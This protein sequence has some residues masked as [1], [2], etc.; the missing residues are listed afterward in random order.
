MDMPVTDAGALL[1]RLLAIAD[2]AVIVVDDDLQVIVFNQGAERV[3]G[4]SAADAIG[5]PL[6]R[7]IPAPQRARHD[8]LVRGFARSPRAAQR[9]GERSHVQG[10]RADGSLFDAEA[11]I[12]HVEIDGR[13]FFTAILR[14]VT[15]SRAAA[16]ALADSEAR[17]RGLASAAPVG[18][19]LT[20]AEGGCSYVNE[21]WCEISG[22]SAAEAVGQG[23]AASLHPADRAPV[24][25]AWRAAV[26]AGL[27]FHL[28]YRFVRADGRETWVVG[29][30][31]AQRTSQGG[32]SGWIGT[33][34]D[35][36]DS[37][38]QAAELERAKSEAEAATRAKSLFLANMSH[39]IRTPLNA[40]IGMTTL[41]Q[42]TPMSED[43][44]D[45]AQTIQSSSE[46][47]LEIINDILDYSKADVGKL[48]LERR[49]FDLRH[50][51]EESLDLVAP[52]ALEKGINL[53]YQIADG[54]PEA[55]V[56]D[57]I[58]LRQILTNLLSNAVKF[59]HQGEVLA[60]VESEAAADGSVALHIAVED[61]GI[62]IAAEHLPR[63]FQRFT[64]VDPSTTRKY[65]GTGLGL[66]IT[67]RLAELMG[68]RVQAESTPGRGS[69][70]HAWVQLERTA[71][72]TDA[73]YLQRNAPALAGKRILI[74]DDNQTNRRI[75]TRFALRWGMQPSTLPSALEALDRVRHGDAFDIALL[76][77]SMPDC[78]GLELARELHAHAARPMP[79]VLLTSLGQRPAGA[80]EVPLAACLA[81]PIKAAQLFD[82]LVAVVSGQVRAPSPSPGRTPAAPKQALRVLIAEDHPINQ[83]V[84]TRLLQHLG[85]HAD[86]ADN[87]AVAIERASR[88]EYDVVLM[89][90]QMPEIDGLEAARAI[91]RRRGPQGLPRIIAMTASAMPGD[92]EA[93]LAAGMD[94]YLAKPI[95]LRD[96]ADAL[97]RVGEA[98]QRPEAASQGMTID[99]SRLEHLRSM[100]DAS[101]P[102]LVRELIDMF[103]GDSAVHVQRIADALAR[104]DAAA[105]RMLA[106]R[107]LS[108]TQN[109]GALRLSAL[110]SAAEALARQGR[111]EEAATPIA[112]LPVERERALAELKALRLRY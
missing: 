97:G 81:K 1:G 5:A 18:I 87:G 34:T 110:C 104:R 73:P 54:T 61:T 10:Q 62:G 52:R 112:A 43:Q 75:L 108:A 31:V 100:Q 59:T 40:V 29:N 69:V 77:M 39:E 48:E 14:D 47:L 106:H 2:D 71:A 103:E 42:D 37:V 98:P 96:L 83:R 24:R 23:W 80:S 92:R 51:V 44:R 20:D 68:G 16:R 107:F 101:Q 76:D 41:L 12:A 94:G 22:L 89:D 8:A 4:C 95:E 70:F 30:A 102:S 63:L 91:V 84:V 25:A 93:C 58:R 33:V 46:A 67:K 35:V 60:S 111:F 6:A 72:P 66:A 11:S 64:Q 85:H 15:D 99:A 26:E 88:Q 74:V 86:V 45:F 78:D 79:L 17:F 57:A 13:M 56:G 3:F 28:R 32:V 49:S 19:F 9:M 90:I 36:T 38:Q 27:P 65:G 53:A 21:R 7:W 55:L 82:T 105:L 50:V 109:I